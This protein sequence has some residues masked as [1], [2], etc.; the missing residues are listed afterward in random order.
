MNKKSWLSRV[1][2]WVVS[3]VSFFAVCWAA[4]FLMRF[5]FLFVYRAAVTAEVKH[6]LLQSL[7]IG[8]KFDM[9]LAAFL[10]IPLGLFVFAGSFFK[11]VPKILKVI[12]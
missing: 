8:A 10:A 11:R 5:V 12:M 9:R 1:P 7:Y 2:K 6:Y 4:F 3:Y